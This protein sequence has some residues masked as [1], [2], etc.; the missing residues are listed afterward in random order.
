MS[1]KK[2][3]L[4]AD[5]TTTT[6]TDATVMD[7]LTTTIQSDTVLTGIYGYGQKAMLVVGGM[8]LQNKRIT[9]KFNPF[10]AKAYQPVFS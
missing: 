4:A 8:V 3:T 1:S 5:G 2:I 10:G 6:V 7:I 9:G